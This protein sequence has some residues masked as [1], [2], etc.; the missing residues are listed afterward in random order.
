MNI[1]PF[2][3]AWDC[4]KT[5][6]HSLLPKQ[7]LTILAGKLAGIQAGRLTTL[8]IAWYVRH[9]KVNMQEAVNP[10]ITTYLTFQDFFTRPLRPELRPVANADFVCPVDG[11]INQFGP[12]ERDQILQAKG[13]CYSISAIIGANFDI[14][15]KFE[16]GCF[17]T[18]YLS[19]GD[20]HRVHMPC[21]G[22]LQQMIHIPGTLYSVNPKTANNIPGLFAR[23]ERVV[24]IFGSTF[25]S[26]ALILVGAT[27][28]GSIATTWH[29]VINAKRTKTIRRWSYQE[30][31]APFLKKGEEMGLFSL[32]STVIVLFPKHTIEFSP[33]WSHKRTIC[34]GEYMG[35]LQG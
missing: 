29:G 7:A 5:L 21:D 20:Y 17:A 13:Q 24:C 35:D 25:G 18:L 9:Y 6:F 34:T 23:N 8:V 28:V 15:S 26:F 16:H 33:K 12:I 11:A 27:I 4:L 30:N 31:S 22:R 1:S 14:S 2:S 32:G 3:R 10:D 19:P